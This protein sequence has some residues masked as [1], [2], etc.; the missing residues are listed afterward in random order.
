MLHRQRTLLY[1]LH[2]AGG[3]AT[4]LH[5]TKWS[6]LL[7]QE[8]E[9]RGGD[10]FYEFVPYRLGPFSFCLFQEAAALKEQGFLTEA[11]EKTWQVTESGRE[12]A[13]KTPMDVR[14]D[15]WKVFQ[16]YGKMD[17]DGL[18]DSLYPR[19]PQYTYLS[20]RKVLAKR[21]EANSAVFT[22]GYEGLTADG[23]LDLLVQNGIFRLI[24]VRHNPVARRYG[25]HRSTLGRLC[26][27]L[28]I[29]YVHVPELGIRS[30]LRQALFAQ[31]DRDRL[32]DQYASTTLIDAN[33]QIQ[34]VAELVK[35]RPSALMCMEAQPCQCHR[36]RLADAVAKITGLPI[37]HLLSS[38]SPAT[39]PLFRASAS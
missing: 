5:V 10:S 26:G 2:L 30:E 33:A 28:A 21:P 1:F 4:H 17:R 9:T 37:R 34:R 15:A 20:T 12:A 13:L 31:E 14:H 25:F 24:D 7:A 3:K 32:F 6:F 8:G 35:E 27:N 38:W 16:Q 36:S 22:V 29:D 18:L 39:L 11:D 23:F 19:Y